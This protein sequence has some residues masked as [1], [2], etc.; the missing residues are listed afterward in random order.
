MEAST[1]SAFS[2]NLITQIAPAG[3]TSWSFTGLS[4]GIAYYFQVIATS[5]AG[6]ACASSTASAATSGTAAIPAEPVNV[7]ASAVSSSQIN[8]SWAD[9]SLDENGFTITVATNPALTQVVQTL[10]ATA[11]A[12]TLP[13]Y[14][15][16]GV[17]DYYVEVAAFNTAGTSAAAR[18]NPPLPHC[19]LR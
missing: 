15:L 18:C 4:P 11:D 3:S 17:T 1:N 8:V 7:S 19:R 12:T 14:D 5:P 13:I 16:N 10:T 6:D 9:S 2:A